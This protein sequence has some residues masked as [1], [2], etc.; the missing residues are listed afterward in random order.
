MIR[1]DNGELVVECEDCG[2]EYYGGTLEFHE[3]VEHLKDSDWI[4][5]KVADRWEHIC[6]DC[7]DMESEE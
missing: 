4:V 5:H 2:H 3:F 1:R 7:Q 6:P